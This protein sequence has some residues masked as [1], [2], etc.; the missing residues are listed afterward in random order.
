[1]STPATLKLGVIG[2]SEGNGHP[3]SWSAIFNGY[4]REAMASCPFAAIP[5]YLA[6]QSFPQDALSGA[7]V[8]HIW[9]QDRAVSEHVARA[10]LIPNIVDSPEGF[11]GHVDG[12]LLARDDAENHERHAAPFLAAGLPVYIDKPLSLSRRGA[13]Q[14]FEQAR[15]PGQIFSCSA[16]RYAP[17]LQLTPARRRR[18]GEIRFIDAIVPKYWNTYAVHAIEPVLALL[19]EQD[20]VVSHHRRHAGGITQLIV[21]WA[22]GIQTRFTSTGSA[23]APISLSVYGTRGWITLTFKDSFRCFKAAL[24]EFIASARSR[25]PA[26]APQTTL[27]VVDLIEMGRG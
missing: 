19:P 20:T 6:R 24:A 23:V 14:L 7:R 21:E 12:V 18:V 25:H 5:A 13:L 22:G 11:L 15:Y 9:T 2:L 4:D 27:K 3:Y 16:L 26:I 8:T 17:E 1:M 10:S